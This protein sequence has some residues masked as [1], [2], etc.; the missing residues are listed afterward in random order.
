MI[1]INVW[2]KKVEPNVLGWDTKGFNVFFK[3]GIQLDPFNIYS[4]NKILSI[5]FV[6]SCDVH[7][8]GK[9]RLKHNKV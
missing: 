2:N 9:T 1:S 5:L 8:R 3:N 7:G 4:T 6:L